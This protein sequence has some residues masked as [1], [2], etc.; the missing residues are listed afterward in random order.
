MS[1]VSLYFPKSPLLILI[2]SKASVG[3]ALKMKFP[4]ITVLMQNIV[5]FVLHT[6]IRTDKLRLQCP[7]L[8]GSCIIY[9]HFMP[10]DHP[11]LP[12]RPERNCS[13]MVSFELLSVHNSHAGPF[14]VSV[15]PPSTAMAP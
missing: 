10:S 15:F 5:D 14:N 1:S 11:I 3:S 9:I 13:L 12:L 2:S 8:S 4:S 7:L 6:E